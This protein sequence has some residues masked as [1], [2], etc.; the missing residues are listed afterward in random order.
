M[1]NI[2]HFVNSVFTSRTYILSKEGGV[3][4]GMSGNRICVTL[5]VGGLHSGRVFGVRY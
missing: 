4:K 2:S 5:K 3:G 1:L